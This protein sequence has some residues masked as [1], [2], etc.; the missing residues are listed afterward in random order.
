MTAADVGDAAAL[1]ELGLHA[2]EGEDPGRHEVDGV[3]RA[4]EVFGAVEVGRVGLM[5]AHALS[6]PEDLG[7]PGLRLHDGLGQQE[8]AREV[9]IE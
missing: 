2:V 4:E 7:D 3:P 9:G 1:L 5:P 6:R 8:R